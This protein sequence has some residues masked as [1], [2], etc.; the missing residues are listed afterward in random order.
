M[1]HLRAR[2]PGRSAGG[3]PETPACVVQTETYARSMD[4]WRELSSRDSSKRGPRW[5]V[6]HSPV[7]RMR[8]MGRTHQC[9]GGNVNEFSVTRP[10]DTTTGFTAVASGV[11]NACGAVADG[12]VT[13][14]GLYDHGEVPAST[15]T[16]ISTGDR[17]T[18]GIR[19]D[20][21]IQCWGCRDDPHNYTQGWGA[22][23]PA[24]RVGAGFNE[25]A[26]WLAVGSGPVATP[27]SVKAAFPECQASL[28]LAGS[29]GAAGGANCASRCTRR[30]PNGW[31]GSDHRHSEHVEAG[32]C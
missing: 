11:D 6:G 5:L 26:G 13:C 20:R 15:F 28:T 10:P 18:C 12:P 27:C 32:V 3:A 1:G 30:C 21:T 19:T 2:S 22:A 29:G 7:T 17:Y 23:K 25:T 8:V 16:T 24:R 14:W 9:W 31:T 4:S